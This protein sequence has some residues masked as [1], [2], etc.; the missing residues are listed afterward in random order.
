MAKNSTSFRFPFYKSIMPGTMLMAERK[1][2]G[3]VNNIDF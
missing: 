3:R 2:Y 1:N